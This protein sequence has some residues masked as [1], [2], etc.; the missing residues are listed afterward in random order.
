MSVSI[1]PLVSEY[2][3]KCKYQMAK[4]YVALSR[5]ISIK[6][7]TVIAVILLVFANPLLNLYTDSESVKSII[8]NVLIIIIIAQFIQNIRD[9][10]AGGLRGSGD[11]KYI[12][13]FTIIAD[14]LLKVILAYVFIN[15]LNF[16]LKAIWIV[17]ILDELL[18]AILF[19]KRFNSNKWHDIKIIDND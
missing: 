9:V 11:T 4:I 18:K 17:I 14:A 2:I 16:D 8:K 13:K 12:A 1:A 19:N 15:I 5:K 7:S 10:Y 3:G 6:L